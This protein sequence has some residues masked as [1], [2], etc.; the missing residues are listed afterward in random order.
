M[1]GSSDTVT[2]TATNVNN[3]ASKENKEPGVLAT[4]KFS[5]L[6]NPQMTQKKF[7]FRKGEK[8][9]SKTIS[10]HFSRFY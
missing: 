6:L 9:L 2:A 3:S 7:V 10:L 8:G 5:S 1:D 4:S